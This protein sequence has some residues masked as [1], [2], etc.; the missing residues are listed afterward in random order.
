MKCY[1]C[2]N[3]SA[4]SEQERKERDLGAVWKGIYAQ[5]AGEFHSVLS[6]DIIGCPY[7]G[8]VRINVECIKDIRD[9][10]EQRQRREIEE[11][12]GL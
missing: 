2:G 4:N 1:T 10:T 8:A 5:G 6:K 7:C 11:I 9:A 12:M 3:E